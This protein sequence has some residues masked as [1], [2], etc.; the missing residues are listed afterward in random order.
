V[1]KNE[2]FDNMH[3]ILKGQFDIAIIDSDGG[4]VLGRCYNFN[5]GSNSPQV[6]K[7]TEVH[8]DR[9]TT[10]L[11]NVIKEDFSFGFAIR[12]LTS[13]G[14]T[15]LLA[16]GIAPT[17]D[18]HSR[19]LRFA[20]QGHMLKDDRKSAL[21]KAYRLPGITG[22]PQAHSATVFPGASNII[23]AEGGVGTFAADDYYVWV[24]PVFRDT[25][26][27]HGVS[28]ADFVLSNWANLVRGEHFN[29][30]TPVQ[31][32]GAPQAILI[33]KAIDVAFDVPADAEGVATPTHY[34]IVVGTVDDIEDADSHV[35]ALG[36]W[37]G[38]A[39]PNVSITAAGTVDFDTT[40]AL[41]DEVL[42]ETGVVTAEVRVWTAM[43]EDTDYTVDRTNNTIKRIAGG[44]ISDGELVRISVWYNANPSELS[45]HGAVGTGERYEWIRFSNF[46]A[47]GTD[48]DS[49]QLEGVQV[50]MPRVNTA[51]MTR[52]L[53]SAAKDGFHDPIAFSNMLAE[54]DTAEEC[55]VMVTPFSRDNAES[56]DWYSDDITPQNG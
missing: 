33:N 1:S 36:A 32:T 15:R 34:I 43:V 39:S 20:R 29:H 17:I 13:A 3:N 35:A 10:V 50:D 22:L 18:T 45:K 44:S 8:N 41:A 6:E 25:D 14:R 40:P 27:K 23:A 55:A 28:D 37:V 2:T 21:P 53:V 5:P 16:D 46:R 31:E 47:D 38:G 51:A 19:L 54:Y 9:E 48:P 56:L 24:V 12:D 52:A 11:S 30:G 49:R 42:V 26:Y 4:I 7:L